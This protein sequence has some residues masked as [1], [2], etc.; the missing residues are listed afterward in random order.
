MLNLEGL[1]TRYDDPDSI[2]AE[3]A[4]LPEV[5]ATARMQEIYREDI[6]EELIYKRIREVK[7][8]GYV[9][10]ASLTPQ[11]VERFHKLALEAELDILVIQGTVV[12][13]EHVSSRA[14]PLNLK[15]GP[16]RWGCWL[17]WDRGRPA[18]PAACWGSASPRRPRSPT[19][20]ERGLGIST[21]RAVT[22]TS[23]PT[24][25]CGRAVTSP[26]RSRVERT[27]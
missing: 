10:A 17:V 8:A 18:R 25:G 16:G 24:A 22:V 13:A 7:D 2:L 20:P 3:I 9:A 1:Q 19:P 12:S 4:E 21:R 23:S 27:R 14:E 26:R 11:K 6:K 5:R 15:R